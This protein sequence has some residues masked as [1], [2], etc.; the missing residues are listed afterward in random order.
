M[1]C[2]CTPQ[3][4]GYK[5]ALDQASP[6]PVAALWRASHDTTVTTLCRPCPAKGDFESLVAARAVEDMIQDEC[7]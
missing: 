2:I 3:M 4:R 6:L 5:K 7:Q 1:T